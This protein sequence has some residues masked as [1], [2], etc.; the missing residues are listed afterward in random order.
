MSQTNIES[1]K[2][3]AR[4]DYSG[5]AKHCLKIKTKSKGLQPFVLNA[6]QRIVVRKIRELESKG[7]PVRICVVKGRQ[8]GISTV[9]QGH[10]AHRSFNFEANNSLVIGQNND[11]TGQLFEKAE[12]MWE[13]LP[14]PLRPVKDSRNKGKKLVFGKPLHSL[15][16]VESAE[17]RD[18]GRSGT[19]QHVHATEIPLWPDAKRTM[20]G[21][22]ESVPEEPGTSVIVESTARGVGDYFHKMYLSA[23]KGPGHKDWNGFHHIF[24]PWYIHE[25]YKREKRKEDAP[26]S[27]EEG[28]L[29][30]K[31]N[32]S[33]EQ[34]LFYRDKKNRLGPDIVKQEYPFTDEEAFLYSGRPY[35]DIE[36]LERTQDL[37]IKEPFIKGDFF[38]SDGR[39]KIRDTGDGPLWIW[40][41]PVAGELYTVSLDPAG[42]G[43]DF[44]GIQVLKGL[45]QVASYKGDLMPDDGARYLYR[46][47]RLYND[48]LA[49]PERNGL[50]YASVIKLTEDLAY[51]NTY[52]HVIEGRT[53]EIESNDYGFKT[54]PSSRPLLL[55]K[56]ARLHK[57]GEI[58]IRC[59]RT[60]D[61]MRTFVVTDNKTGKGEAQDGEHDDLVMS[62][63][64]A[65]QGA[66]RTPTG[67]VEVYFASRTPRISRK[68]GY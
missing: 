32:L 53:K 38:P 60:L 49:V 63:A 34:M 64:L 67:S 30:E 18:A 29:I 25:E 28:A 17:N 7:L 65:V 19:F 44:T 35:F 41:K 20:D 15:M 4:A 31:Y 6:A 66:E 1:L 47:C 26:F 61:E 48:A 68:L 58:I 14:E 46:L 10:L 27:E 37:H 54:T 2:R 22:L 8:M 59:Q 11:M 42:G 55:E 43:D 50:G 3:K 39:Y 36:S 33:D 52:R 24:L 13:N 57:Q 16:Y 12:I 21:L 56:L 23:K 51:T 62:L 5:Y 45:E 40:E 9:S